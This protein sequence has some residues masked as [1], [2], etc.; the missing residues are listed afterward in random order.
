M[1]DTDLLM[2]KLKRGAFVGV[3]SFAAGYVGSQI[4]DRT[5]L[6]EIQVSGAKVALGAGV[7]YVST[8]DDYLDVSGTAQ[9]VGEFAG[10]G[11]Q[12]AG[13]SEIGSNFNADLG[14]G[15]RGR[16]A[17]NRGRSRR[18]AKRTVKTDGGTG[19]SDYD[20]DRGSSA[21]TSEDFVIDA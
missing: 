19:S 17:S 16:R 9:D 4:A 8:D 10:Y 14:G 6:S 2:E 1:V 3:G 7:S 20:S 21:D 15:G 13:W 5:E 12:G 18:T 11:M